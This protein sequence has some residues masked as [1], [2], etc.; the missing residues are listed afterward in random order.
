MLVVLAF[1]FIIHTFP[2]LEHSSPLPCRDIRSIIGPRLDLYLPRPHP[3]TIRP[4]VIFQRS[5]SPFIRISHMDDGEIVIPI[6]NHCSISHPHYH[7]LFKFL[8]LHSPAF[9]D[10]YRWMSRIV[11]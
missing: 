8:V 5:S 3:R 2:G 11:A 4:S 6:R 1:T 9:A 7:F 10:W